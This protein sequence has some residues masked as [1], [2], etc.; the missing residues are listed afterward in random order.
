MS[1][2]SFNTIMTT[3]PNRNRFN[4][5][6]DLKLSFNMGTLV[7]TAA[8]DVIPGD[9]FNISVENMLRFAPLV[10]PVMHDIE[11]KTFWFFVPNRL[12]WP[13]WEDFITGTDTDLVKPYV[14]NQSGLMSNG[15]IADYMGVPPDIPQTMEIDAMPFAGYALIYDEW[16]RDQNLID[17]VFVPLVEGN[18]TSNYATFVAGAPVKRAWK[19]DYFTSALPFAQKGDAVTLPLVD[20]GEVLVERN[21]TLAAWTVW[22]ASAGIGVGGPEDIG[23]D[24]SSTAL[25]A[26][27]GASNV[28]LD[29]NG[30]LS[31]DI[32]AS[33]VTINALR[34][35]FRMQEF[36][37]LDAV[38]GSRYTET[39]Y[40]HFGVRTQDHR[41]QRPELIGAFSGKMVISE[42]L[43]TAAASG[44]GVSGEGDSS[45]LGTMGGHG[46]SVNGGRNLNYRAT[47]HGW[48]IGLINVCPRA[49]YQQGLP[50]K[51][52]RL[53][54][55]DYFWPKLAN[56]GEQTILNQE[57][58]TNAADPDGTFGYIPRYSEYRYESN[59]VSGDM[60]AELSHWH[61]GR[62]FDSEPALNPDF[63][64]QDPSARIFA[65]QYEGGGESE[66]AGAQIY[67]HIFNNI[68]C[69]RLIPK[70]GRPML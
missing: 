57:I 26:T 29:P 44:T 47:E 22:D 18:N 8:I 69:S 16:F 62:I 30:T 40:A 28:G 55:E 51:F 49:S 45:P 33:A 19:H 64:N 56:I 10:A 6:H 41:Q 3:R 14:L 67:G 7:P 1:S 25:Q 54:R 43:Q 15:C 65:V 70:Y 68:S 5:S 9:V 21:S 66:Y 24:P 37:E 53:T 12:V 38:G 23:I 32:N 20:T 52:S 35:A 39:I 31:V 48:I 36:L 17:E 34:E 42:V 46:I 63:I 61:L 60:R 13:E 11:I 50:R 59:R 4:L 2:N 58:Y 27:G